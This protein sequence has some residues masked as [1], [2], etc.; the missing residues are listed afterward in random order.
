MFRKQA[1]I[2]AAVMLIIAGT[3]LAAAPSHAVEATPKPDGATASPSLP[4]CPLTQTQ[5]ERGQKVVADALA[6]VDRG[7]LV[8]FGA[9]DPKPLATAEPLPM[10]WSDVSLCLA[11]LQDIDDKS[12]VLEDAL[13]QLGLCLAAAAIDGRNCGGAEGNVRAALNDLEV[14]VTN[15]RFTCPWLYPF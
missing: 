1:T 10:N 15:L 11:A 6:T 12:K 4:P 3:A 5:H 7:R 14:A 13:E 9:D 8:V 2:T